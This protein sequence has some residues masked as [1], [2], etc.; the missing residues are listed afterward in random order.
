MNG[1]MV[2]FL[3][4]APA[5]PP[6]VRQARSRRTDRDTAKQAGDAAGE[7]EGELGRRVLATLIELERHSASGATAHDIVMRL[8]FSGDAPEQNSVSRRLTSLMRHGH[9]VDSGERKPS[10]RRHGHPLVVWASTQGGRA[11]LR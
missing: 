5:P 1:G 2:S 3:G 8:A 9:V 6:K 10:A 4:D 7:W 11:W